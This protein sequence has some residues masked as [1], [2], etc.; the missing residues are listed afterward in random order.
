MLQPIALPILS[1]GSA[2]SE[3]SDKTP[4][5]N[6]GSTANSTQF[7]KILALQQ[8]MPDGTSMV[9]SLPVTPAADA[10]P[11][12]TPATTFPL[13]G[14][15]LPPALPLVE[16]PSAPVDMAAALRANSTVAPKPATAAPVN[17]AAEP[18]FSAETPAPA[19]RQFA[20]HIRQTALPGP[21]V[22]ARSAKAATHITTEPAPENEVPALEVQ[23]L[24]VPVSASPAA[25][26]QSIPTETQP[27]TDEPRS[28]SG[29][30][31][32]A[33]AGAT[34]APQRVAVNTSP[35]A[36]SIVVPAAMDALPVIP[37]VTT[38]PADVAP[39]ASQA[40]APA[41]IPVAAA[42]QAVK[43]TETAQPLSGAVARLRVASG[44]PQAA[45]KRPASPAITASEP[46]SLPQ[47]QLSAMPLVSD[48]PLT[49]AAPTEPR[50]DFSQ[51]VDRLV[52]AREAAMPHPVHASL[53]HAEFGQVQ[54]TFAHDNAGL[55]VAMAS[56][57]PDF[58][59]AVAA[60]APAERQ[61][62]PG[63]T[64]GQSAARGD[65]QGN[66]T[67]ST[68]NQPQGQNQSGPQQNGGDGR[69]GR[70]LARQTT[71][72]NASSESAAPAPGRAGIFA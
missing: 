56:N 19:V 13:T 2:M 58:A 24:G 46:V 9:S 66:A 8:A 54:L 44:Q 61:S 72:A 30:R 14:K 69:S 45:D 63:D 12:S 22:A 49:T 31:P 11:A 26:A 23:L 68:Q 32:A 43:V 33:A 40:A 51:L 16:M 55:T 20:A 62:G 15:T 50:H 35:V 21:V 5:P 65:T 53:N 7:T 64:S 37:T 27:G 4:G 6:P 60:A 18:E 39:V 34:P 57:D 3:M 71:A 47:P 28:V 52:A 70:P 25:P 48:Q 1:V 29:E 41:A 10:D 38:A 67:P 59:R 17:A 42:L 36:A